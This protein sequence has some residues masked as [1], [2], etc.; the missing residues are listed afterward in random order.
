[1][2]NNDR[3]IDYIY[4]HIYQL[5]YLLYNKCTK[6]KKQKMKSNSHDCIAKIIYYVL[7]LDFI[8]NFT[9]FHHI[10]LYAIIIELFLYYLFIQKTH[11][12]TMSITAKIAIKM[13]AQNASNPKFRVIDVRT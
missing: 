9:R 13:I 11:T 1:M 3:L 5:C 12:T 2:K 4:N 7:Y 8:I 10:L 6:M